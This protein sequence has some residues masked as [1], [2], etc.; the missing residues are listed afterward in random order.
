MQRE[1][2]IT[3]LSQMEGDS[4]AVDVHGVLIDVETVTTDRGTVV[5][6]VNQEDLVDILTKIADGRTPV[7]RPTS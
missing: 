1:D 3:R 4:V 5:L 2:L 7:R 6:V